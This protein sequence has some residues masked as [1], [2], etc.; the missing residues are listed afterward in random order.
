MRQ[1]LCCR[2]QHKH[3]AFF[4]QVGQRDDDVELSSSSSYS[5]LFFATKKRRR[6]ATAASESFNGLTII[7]EFITDECTGPKRKEKGIVDDVRAIVSSHV[8]WWWWWNDVVT[9]VSIT[10]TYS[11]RTTYGPSSTFQILVGSTR[12]VC[13]AS[14]PAAVAQLLMNVW[15]NVSLSLW[16]VLHWRVP[17]FNR[18]L[19]RP[20]DW[21]TVCW[22]SHH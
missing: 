13:S 16:C 4:F 7:A 21:R 10:H 3:C 17:V 18:I 1:K 12:S 19:L 20:T 6:K 5:S 11:S 22:F 15:T 2:P 8:R 14:A 9:A